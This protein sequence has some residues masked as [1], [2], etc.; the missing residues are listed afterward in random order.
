MKKQRVI[1]NKLTTLGI[2]LGRI[3]THTPKRI[4]LVGGNTQTLGGKINKIKAKIRDVTTTTTMQLTNIPHRDHINTTLTT[5]LHIHTKTKI[6]LLIHPIPTHHHLM[7]DSQGLRN[8]L[9]AYARRFKIKR[10]SRRRCEPISRIRETP[11][12]GWNFKW[13]TYLRIF[14]NLL[15]ASQVTQRK[16]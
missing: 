12:R 15:I 4:I 2:H 9:K 14:P 16:I 7:T 8:Y 13:D 6:T 3:M 11:S 5:P 10:C 1:R